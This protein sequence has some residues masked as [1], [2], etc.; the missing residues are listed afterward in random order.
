MLDR[1]SPSLPFSCGDGGDG[2]PSTAGETGEMGE[3]PVGGVNAEL[4]CVGGGGPVMTDTERRLRLLLGLLVWLLVEVAGGEGRGGAGAARG[5]VWD[6][7]G[8]RRRSELCLWCINGCSCCRGWGGLL[9]VEIES[10]APW[11]D[12]APTAAAPA[13]ALA[14]SPVSSRELLVSSWLCFP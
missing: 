7:P 13:A 4:M 1:R 6:D 12:L 14:A 9:R 2:G 5:V 3:T 10:L 11:P 8:G